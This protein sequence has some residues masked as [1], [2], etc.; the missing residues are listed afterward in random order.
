[1]HFAVPFVKVFHGE[2][3]ILYVIRQYSFLLHPKMYAL[4]KFI[5]PYT[6]VY[7]RIL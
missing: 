3:V 7:P 2:K 4:G 5:S 6:P 1:M